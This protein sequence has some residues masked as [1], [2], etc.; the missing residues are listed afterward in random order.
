MQA[1]EAD[2]VQAGDRQQA[3]EWRRKLHH[4]LDQLFQKD[5]TAGADYHALQVRPCLPLAPSASCLR[6][7]A[8]SVRLK[9]GFKLPSGIFALSA[10]LCRAV[11]EWSF[12]NQCLSE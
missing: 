12:L 6:V 11:T 2:A 3:E 9:S 8:A 5:Q 10:L 4:Y 7:T 1:E